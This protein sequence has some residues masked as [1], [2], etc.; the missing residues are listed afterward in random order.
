MATNNRYLSEKAKA[1]SEKAITSAQ[2]HATKS[3]DAQDTVVTAVVGA[4]Y[5]TG[6]Y[7]KTFVTTYV[8]SRKPASL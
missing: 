1:R 3:R 5:V 2:K 6:V 7:T 4:T 8:A